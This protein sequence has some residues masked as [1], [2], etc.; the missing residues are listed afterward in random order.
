MK[1]APGVL[2]GP[3]RAPQAR[4]VRVPIAILAGALLAVIY[5]FS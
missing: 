4:R 5:L 3:H 1:L 2:D